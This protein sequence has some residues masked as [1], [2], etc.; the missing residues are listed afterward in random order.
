MVHREV[1]FSE[2]GGDVADMMGKTVP[3]M[4]EAAARENERSLVSEQWVPQASE[5]IDQD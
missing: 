4:V 1:G 2:E 5:C 3:G